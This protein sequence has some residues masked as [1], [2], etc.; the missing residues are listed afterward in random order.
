[1]RILAV[2]TK[3]PFPLNEGR[4]LRTYNLLRELARRHEVSLCSYIQSEAEAQ[5]V[6]HMREFCAAVH[7]VP[8]YIKRPRFELARDLLRDLPSGAP[9]LATKYQQPAMAAL[10][11]QL[12]A[13]DRFDVLHLDML[14]LGLLLKVADGLPTVLVEH[15]V[16]S[17]L[18]ERRI[19]R[20]R[21]ALARIYLERQ[22]RKLRGFEVKT[23]RAVGC[24]VCVSD[25]DARA[26]REMCGPVETVMVP[27]AVDVEYFR[28]TTAAPRTGSLI[29]VGGLGWFP[30]LD[31]IEF[32]AGDILPRIAREVPEV[33][34]TVVGE[35]P[36]AKVVEKLRANGRIRFAGLVDD[37]RPYA[38]EAAA[39]VVP[40]RIGGGTRL[41][42]L[43]AL[44]M[45]KPVITTSVGCEGLRV[46]HGAELLVA[47]D[48]ESFARETVRVLRNASLASQLGRA[49]RECVMRHYQW[50]DAARLMEK[51]YAQAID[52]AGS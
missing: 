24:V 19:A 14:H 16:E 23:C 38:A 48:A 6:E 15:N 22:L 12:I 27:N 37:I 10:L 47:D 3:S 34:L 41:K 45:G 5:G 50:S 20:C 11:R 29:Y 52:A 35:V 51:A 13:R 26:L 18:L 36:D 49:G 33:S 46:A 40:L 4:A 21:S 8:L 28:A 31:A 30:N 2:T 1:L 9:L 44:A 7:A 42:I 43:D 17:T 25:H 32:F 39:Y